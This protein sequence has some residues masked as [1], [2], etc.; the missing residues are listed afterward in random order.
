[1]QIFVLF[2]IKFHTVSHRFLKAGLQQAIV[3]ISTYFLAEF[4]LMYI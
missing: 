1:M 2:L 3:F 4:Y